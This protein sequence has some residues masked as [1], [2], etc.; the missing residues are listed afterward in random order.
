MYFDVARV[1][2]SMSQVKMLL[3]KMTNNFLFFNTKKCLKKKNEVCSS[4]WNYPKTSNLISVQSFQTSIN[5]G[6][7]WEQQ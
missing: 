1:F 5:Y 3:P 4:Q 7:T 6:V 2:S